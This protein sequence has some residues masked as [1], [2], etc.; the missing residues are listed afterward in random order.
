GR[1]KCSIAIVKLMRGQGLFL[2]N[3]KDLTEYFQSL[4]KNYDVYITSFGGG[5]NGQSEAIK[6][7]LSRSIYNLL[8]ENNKKVLKSL[9]FLTRNSSVKERR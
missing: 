2:I 8:D 7:S 3:G 4:E 5:L 1:R 6:L 9:G